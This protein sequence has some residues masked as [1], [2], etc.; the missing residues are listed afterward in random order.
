MS[1]LCHKQ[2]FHRFVGLPCHQYAL[3]TVSPP[4]PKACSISQLAMRLMLSCRA[5]TR[6]A[7]QSYKPTFFMS[8]RRLPEKDKIHVVTDLGLHSALGAIWASGACAST[9]S[10]GDNHAGK[11]RATPR[12]V[13][14]GKLWV[15]CDQR[16]RFPACRSQGRTAALVNRRGA[17][18][19]RYWSPS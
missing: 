13:G 10:L 11:P 4:N 8:F 6:I 18:C 3:A 17:F 9:I 7:A 19:A 16:S 2:T 5:V 14:A 15:I 12:A 1:A